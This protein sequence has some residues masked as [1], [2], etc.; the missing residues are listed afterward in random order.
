MSRKLQI[1]SLIV[2][3]ACIA[4][5]SGMPLATMYKLH[6]LDPWEADP[7]QLKVALRADDRI[8]ISEGGANMRFKF[9]AEDGGLSFDETFII[10]ISR[11]PALGI[12]L[13]YGKEP[14]ESITVLQLTA[15]DAQELMRLQSLLTPYRNGEKTGSATFGIGV[16][17]TCMSS[18]IPVD[19]ILIDIFLQT[20]NEE[21]FFVFIDNLDLTKQMAE[22]GG[23]VNELQTCEEADV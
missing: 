20:T 5:C 21:G 12:E 2:V 7:A 4:A 14:D 22:S 3:S 19:E 10:E 15:A 16:T 23:N 8:Q 17:G 18:P 11:N 6:R 9:D 13:E 1:C